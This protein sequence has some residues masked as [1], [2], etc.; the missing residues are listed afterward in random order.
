MLGV[1]ET[2]LLRYED[3]MLPWLDAAQLEGWFRREGGEG[4]IELR[5]EAMRLLQRERELQEIAAG[6]PLGVDVVHK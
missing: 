5:D 3:G 2:T 4:W 6:R 1:Q